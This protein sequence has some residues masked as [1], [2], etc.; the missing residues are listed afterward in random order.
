[1]QQ[2]GPYLGAHLGA[3]LSAYV[4]GALDESE[5]ELAQTHLAEC[6]CCQA[7]VR[8]QR[9]LK[10][11]MTCLGMAA[12]SAALVAALSDRTCVEEH[13]ERMDHRRSAFIHAAVTVGS[14]CASL[15]VVGL[16]AGGAAPNAPA[17]PSAQRSPVATSTPR[18]TPPTVPVVVRSVGAGIAAAVNGGRTSRPPRLPA[19]GESA[20]FTFAPSSRDRSLGR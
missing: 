18:V 10:Q 13:V 9:H 8:R 7:Q 17:N 5:H 2:L 12:P 20:L 15:T 19:A 4:D 11:R 14:L 3:R 16:V 6:D 1:M